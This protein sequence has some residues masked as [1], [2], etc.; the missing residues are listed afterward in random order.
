MSLLLVAFMAV[1][2]FVGAQSDQFG[3]EFGKNTGLGT[4]DPRETVALVIRIIMGFLGTIAIVIIL[5][6][7][8][9]WMTAGGNDEKVTEARKLIT[10]GII[11]L[12]II[13]SAYAIT[14][15]VITQLMT[16]TNAGRAPGL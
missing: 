1:P 3:L 4:R 11:G 7:G 10:A 14:N 6:G 13:L 15:F 5:L 9:K 16:A 12:I 8:F 2:F